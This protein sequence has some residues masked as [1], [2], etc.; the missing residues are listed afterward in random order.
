ML[1]QICVRWAYLKSV[2]NTEISAPTVLNLY[3]RTPPEDTD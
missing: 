3:F 2:P 1:Q